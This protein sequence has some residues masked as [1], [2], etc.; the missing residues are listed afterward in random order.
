MG[1]TYEGGKRLM[2]GAISEGM[3]VERKIGEKETEGNLARES[4]A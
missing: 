2:G 1:E 3:W 4:Q